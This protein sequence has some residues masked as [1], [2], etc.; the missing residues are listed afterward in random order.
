MHK[1]FRSN[2]P[3]LL[4][5]LHQINVRNN[6][7]FSF[8]NLTHNTTSIQKQSLVKELLPHLFQDHLLCAGDTLGTQGACKGDS[9]GPLMRQDY[10]QG[11]QLPWTQIGIVEGGIGEC[12]Y[13]D[14]PGVYVR[15]THPEIIGF[16]SSVVNFTSDLEPELKPASP[17][18]KITFNSTVQSF[19]EGNFLQNLNWSKKTFFFHILP[20]H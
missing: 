11:I 14:Y 20:I 10:D 18:E 3:H 17:P 16:V 8:C 4:L 1:N 5:T 9:G 19:L 15:L 6:F 12:G 2:C 7:Y 13:S